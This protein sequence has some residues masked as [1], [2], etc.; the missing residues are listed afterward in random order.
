MLEEN[1]NQSVQDDSAE[2]NTKPEGNVD[3]EAKFG[4]EVK[5][6]KKQRAKRQETDKKNVILES[7]NEKLKKQLKERDESDMMKNGEAEQVIA[8]LKS[9]LAEK[10]N[11]LAEQDIVISKVNKKEEEDRMSLVTRLATSDE[12]KE[13][14]STL[15][16]SALKVMDEKL[17]S[18]QGDNPQA[19]PNVGRQK[20]E[21]PKG[22]DW[23]VMDDRERR[24]NWDDIVSNMKKN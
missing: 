4:E 15:P 6:A 16:Y 7:D 22:E 23:T 19:V 11:K 14:L 17:T 10:D 1:Q 8:N 5:Y 24:K 21:R 3:F 2:S 9:E 12:E 13:K 18:P 20:E